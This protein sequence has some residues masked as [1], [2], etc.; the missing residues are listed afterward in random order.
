MASL[1]RVECQ[2]N[3]IHFLGDIVRLCFIIRIFIYFSRQT[4]LYRSCIAVLFDIATCFGCSLQPSSGR[5]TVHE[6]FNKG[7]KQ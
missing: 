6:K 1:S 2:M 5:T 7:E 4:Q 3:R